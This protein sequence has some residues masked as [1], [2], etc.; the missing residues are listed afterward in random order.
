MSL[1]ELPFDVLELIAQA[2]RNLPPNPVF[3]SQVPRLPVV[4]FASTNRR[5][6]DASLPAL[7]QHIRIKG[8][9]HLVNDIA[10][11]LLEHQT[12]LLIFIR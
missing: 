8:P 3:Y 9:C 4:V 12:A 2:I 5:I 1:S 6:R 10:I 11:N 7:F